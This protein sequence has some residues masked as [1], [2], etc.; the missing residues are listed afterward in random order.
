[1]SR[2]I[3]LALSVALPHAILAA[4]PPSAGAQSLAYPRTAKVTHVDD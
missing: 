1:M 3:R 4:L 2:Q